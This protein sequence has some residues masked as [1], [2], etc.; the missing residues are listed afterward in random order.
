MSKVTSKL[1]NKSNFK[2]KEQHVYF[3]S[4]E[5]M[6]QISDNTVNLTF[7]SP[8][9]WLVKDYHHEK[10]IGRETYQNYL[11]RLNA[12]WDECFRVTKDNGLLIINV[13]TKR[14]L[15]RYYP[16]A[17]DIYKNIKDWKLL[18]RHVWVIPNAL[19]QPNHYMNKLVDNKHEDILIWV[20]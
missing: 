11:K 3:Q 15:G 19:P 2:L 4:S 20:K 6:N 17:M 18:D 14:H 12:V 7:T 10:Q 16:L 13:G 8:P 5:Q 9:Y 1:R